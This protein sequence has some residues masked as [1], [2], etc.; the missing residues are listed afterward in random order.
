MGMATFTIRLNQD[1]RE[2]ACLRASLQSYVLEEHRGGHILD[3]YREELLRD[4][5]VTIDEPSI[6]GK[7]EWLGAMLLHVGEKRS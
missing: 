6:S 1:A 2:K 3:E 4:K 5:E 7:R